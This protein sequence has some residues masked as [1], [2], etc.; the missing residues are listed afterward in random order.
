MFISKNKYEFVCAEGGRGM[1][2]LALIR[3]S[4]EPCFDEFLFTN[5]KHSGESSLWGEKEERKTKQPKQVI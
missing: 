4:E 5:G 1:Q 3:A 2:T